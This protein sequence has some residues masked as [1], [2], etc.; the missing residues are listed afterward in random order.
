MGKKFHVQPK[1][2]I[3]GKE[4]FEVTEESNLKDDGTT[5]ITLFAPLLAMIVFYKFLTYNTT[6][7]FNGQKIKFQ[8]LSGNDKKDLVSFVLTITHFFGGLLFCFFYII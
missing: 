8:V 6:F 4:Y 2:D 1:K 5:G 7:L 3:L